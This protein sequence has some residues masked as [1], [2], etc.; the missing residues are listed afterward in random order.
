MARHLISQIDSLIRR[1]PARRGLVATESEFGPL[2]AGHLLAAAEHL[3]AQATTVGIVTGFYIP[4]G[5]VSAAE[6]D[7]PIGAL[8][9]AATLTAI[10][11]HSFVLTDRFC[12]G[13]VVA[14]AGAIRFPKEH[15]ITVPDAVD[16]WIPAFFSEPPGAELSHLISVER[17]G[18]SHTRQSIESQTGSDPAA[19]AEF[20]AR[21]PFESQGRCHNMR[22][23]VI[24]AHSPP[25]YRLFEALSEFNPQT[26]SIGV[27][28]GAN[29][30]GMGVVPWAELVR[31][32]PGES[33]Y[34]IPCRIGT[35][36][37][38]IAG[39]SNWGAYALAAAVTLLMNRTEI[40][41]EWG[42]EHQ[43]RMIETVVRD[44]PAVDGVTGRPEP[45]VDGLPFP[46]FIQ[47]WTAMRK[48]L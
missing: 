3:A 40:L 13:A 38:I 22:G 14:A 46:T 18:P 9:L 7:G 20:S 36:W 8:V 5:D 33:A 10:G 26:K 42:I 44:G 43:W 2:C 11:V 6:T 16:D 41:S 39:T 32:L 24:D 12:H 4:H 1:D 21:V 30:I 35:D 27:G 23:D 48:L 37:N 45:T 15:V 31:R 47:P 28:D 25:L 17:V 19:I 34:R 29:E